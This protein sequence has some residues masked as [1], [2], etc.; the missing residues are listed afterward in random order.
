LLISKSAVNASILSM[1]L[2]LSYLIRFTS[3]AS[4]LLQQLP[5]IG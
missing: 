3:Y 2:I 1:N 4:G 5:T